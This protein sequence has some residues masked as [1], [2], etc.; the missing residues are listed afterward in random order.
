MLADMVQSFL[1]GLEHNMATNGE[2]EKAYAEITALRNQMLNSFAEIALYN[3]VLG[4]A[5]ALIAEPYRG[6]VR[7]LMADYKDFELT[8]ENAARVRRFRKNLAD[9]F[10]TLG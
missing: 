3:Q 4:D 7:R 5:V 9:R 8:E 6:L 2:L 10:P 1:V